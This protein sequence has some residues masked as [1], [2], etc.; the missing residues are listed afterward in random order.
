MGVARSSNEVCISISALEACVRS[1]LDHAAERRLAVLDPVRVVIT[2]FDKDGA[3]R[4]VTVPNHPAK[5]RE[6]MGT[7]EV[8]LTPV[9]FIPRDKFRTDMV[10]GYKGLV[11]G[12]PKNAHIRLLYA[13][14]VEYESHSVDAE[15]SVTEIRVKY[16]PGEAPKGTN[17]V[18][19]VPSSASRLE[20]RLYDRLFKNCIVDGVEVH[21][22]RAAKELGVDFVDL[23]N[24]DSLHVKNMLV[25]PCVM[26]ELTIERRWQF[27]TVGYFCI[28]RVDSTKDKP[29]LNMVV[30]LKEDKDK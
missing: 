21:A 14:V 23:F 22:E 8:Q 7:R 2:N 20:A 29:V 13:A 16:V 25:E 30:S 3:P 24:E 11:P 17:V 28:D 9:V 1:E 27:I 19:W 10:P 6:E 26:D 12:Q 15:G 4:T 5:G 18:A